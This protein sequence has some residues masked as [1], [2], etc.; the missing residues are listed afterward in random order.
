MAERMWLKTQSLVALRTSERVLSNMWWPISLGEQFSSDSFEK[1][2]SFWLNSTLGLILLLANRQ[3]TRGA[4]VDFKKP[5]LSEA[6]VLDL[7]TI[8]ANA[9]KTLAAA[10][11][12]VCNQGLRPFAE[13]GTDPVRERIDTAFAQALGLPDISVLRVMLAR[14]PVVCLHRI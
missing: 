13:M 5:V 8:P 1:C 3:E 11:D 2:L 4:W 6:P 9:M 12:A 10:Y 14:E 7:R